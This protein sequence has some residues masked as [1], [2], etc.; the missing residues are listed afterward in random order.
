MKPAATVP[1][2]ALPSWRWPIAL[3]ALATVVLHL[4][5]LWENVLWVAVCGSFGLTG[6]LCGVMPAW[7]AMR[8]DPEPALG[9]G[10]AVSFIAVGTG[11][12]SLAIVTLLRGFSIQ[13]EHEAQWRAQYA[14]LDVKPEII[15]EF[16]ARLRGGEGDSWTVLG[17]ALLAFGG[18]IAGAVVAAFRS[19]RATK[20]VG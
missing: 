4:P 7:I 12:L 16:F 14:S 5:V 10:F 1:A 8:R 3:G 20:R 17:A 9:S 6:V 19:R 18:G 11:S 15:V 13:P 2:P